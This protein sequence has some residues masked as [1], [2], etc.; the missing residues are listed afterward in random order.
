MNKI[1]IERTKNVG[2]IPADLARDAGLT[3]PCLR[4]SGVRF[5][6]REAQ[7]YAFYDRLEF[8]VP[9]GRGDMGTLGDC[10]DRY[11]VR[12]LEIL[13]SVKIVRQCVEAMQKETQPAKP[14]EMGKANDEVIQA[15]LPRVVKIQPTEAYVGIENPRGELGHYIVTDGAEKA[16]RLKIRGPSFC[17]LSVCEEILPGAMLADAVAII[18]SVDIVLGEVDR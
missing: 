16:Y 17:N 8:G 2:V 7:P 13:E 9:V 18:G 5:D 15:K 6:L 11:H 1:F 14:K 4:G 10:W 3:G 12:M